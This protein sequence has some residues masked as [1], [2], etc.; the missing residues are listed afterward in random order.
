MLMYVM[1]INN[2]LFINQNVL[3]RSILG[4]LESFGFRFFKRNHWLMLFCHN[5]C[6]CRD[7]GPLQRMRYLY[8][9]R[10]SPGVSYCT[11][12]NIKYLYFF[13][14]F[15]CKLLQFIYSKSFKFSLPAYY[16]LAYNINC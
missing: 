3:Q 6:C 14:L 7:L 1:L 10:G 5:Q 16:F 9:K 12:A 4:F 2:F 15:C 11:Q 13:K 8:I